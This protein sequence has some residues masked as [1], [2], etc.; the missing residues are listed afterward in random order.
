MHRSSSRWVS[1][2]RRI[3]SKTS[4]LTSEGDSS[5]RLNKLY[6]LSYEMSEFK[7]DGVLPIYNVKMAGSFK[8][9]RILTCS[10]ILLNPDNSLIPSHRV[11]MSLSMLKSF[12]P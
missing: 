11:H 5:F 1:A 12:N 6:L 3:A 10:L 8:S 4:S 2:T 9:E 7:Q